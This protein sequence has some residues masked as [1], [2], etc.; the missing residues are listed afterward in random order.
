MR[1]NDLL[2]SCPND[3]CK[4]LVNFEQLAQ[5]NNVYVHVS[6]NSRKLIYQALKR[7]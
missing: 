1:L 4:T 6:L 7:A 5:M 2:V 3:V